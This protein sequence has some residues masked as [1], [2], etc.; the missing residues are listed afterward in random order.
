LRKQGVH[1]LVQRSPRIR[2]HGPVFDYFHGLKQNRL[3]WVCQRLSQ[4]VAEDRFQS[5][6]I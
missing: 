5:G 1:I 3:L 6:L 2:R 4:R